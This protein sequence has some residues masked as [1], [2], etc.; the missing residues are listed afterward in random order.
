[1][2]NQGTLEFWKKRGIKAIIKVC[3]KQSQGTLNSV[4]FEHIKG[5]P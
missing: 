2:D 1:M 4:F 3:Q 5:F